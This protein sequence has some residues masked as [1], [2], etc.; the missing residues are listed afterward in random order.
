MFNLEDYEPVQ[1]RIDR[2]LKDHPDGR[3][4]TDLVP[5]MSAADLSWV[6]FKATL[7][8]DRED[9]EKG[10]ALSTG[11]AVE[12]ATD[13]GVNATSHLE[14]CE[15]SA[16]GRALAN[17]GYHGKLRPSKEE[18]TKAEPAHFA[19]FKTETVRVTPTPQLMPRTLPMGQFKGVPLEDIPH[20]YLLWVVEKSNAHDDTKDMVRSF[21][22]DRALK[23]LA[24]E[25]DAA[26]DNDIPF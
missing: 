2:F 14:N 1:D 8:R 15:T 19:E 6:V 17:I 7:Y 12:H 24:E 4:I 5:S 18:M 25:F 13:R 23:D 9:Q 11:W 22:A 10:L 16:V 21:L 26:V 3:P 20:D